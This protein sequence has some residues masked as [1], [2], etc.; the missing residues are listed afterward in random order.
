[1]HSGNNKVYKVKSLPFNRKRLV[2]HLKER[3]SVEKIE[4]DVDIL[5]TL[6]Y[7]GQEINKLLIH[8][9]IDLFRFH[10]ILGA[11]GKKVRGKGTGRLC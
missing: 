1:M 2:R 10:V 9:Q 7:L 4:E 5:V 8:D 11:I 3:L 6:F